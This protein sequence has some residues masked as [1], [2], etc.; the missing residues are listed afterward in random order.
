MP[1]AESHEVTRKGHHHKLH[2]NSSD[3][4]PNHKCSSKKSPTSEQSQ[5]YNAKRRMKYH[6][7]SPEEK[8]QRSKRRAKLDRERYHSV[9]PE[10]KKERNK[11]RAKYEREL[12]KRKKRE[13][14]A[15]KVA[16]SWHGED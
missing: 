4:R 13:R 6:S 2:H 12:R 11:R 15:A 3:G 10:K 1:E 14:A 8:K 16:A 5:N 7:V 9:S